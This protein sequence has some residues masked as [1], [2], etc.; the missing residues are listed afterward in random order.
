MSKEQTTNAKEESSGTFPNL[1]KIPEELNELLGKGADDWITSKK[2]QG[3]KQ[4]KAVGRKKKSVSSTPEPTSQESAA[5]KLT[6]Q[7]ST[8]QRLASKEQRSQPS[9]PPV[10]KEAGKP[11]KVEKKVEKQVKETIKRE[12]AKATQKASY[13]PF[14]RRHALA[15]DESVR[16]EFFSMRLSGKELIS[17]SK[18]AKRCNMAMSTYVR[19]AALQSEPRE[20]LSKE[21]SELMNKVYDL[22]DDANF[23]IRQ[24]AN[25]FHSM[26]AEK[27]EQGKEK[28]RE[29]TWKELKTVI[30]KQKEVLSLLKNEFGLK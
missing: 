5:E 23:N 19:Q 1:P 13:K 12:K 16:K 15:V 21:E 11:K 3:S 20:A 10:K 7:K 6:S 18:K 14:Q 25:Y 24:M 29:L 28:Y 22:L 27:D 9:S 17:L 30:K 26:L 8:S 2:V 4:T